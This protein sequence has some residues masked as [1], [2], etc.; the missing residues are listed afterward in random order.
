MRDLRETLKLIANASKRP[1]CAIRKDSS[2]LSVIA[3]YCAGLPIE[4]SSDLNEK[5]YWFL[6][7]LETY[8]ICECHGCQNKTA[9]RG[10]KRGYATTCCSKHAAIVSRPKAIKTNLA[11]YG[12]PTPLQNREIR[13]KINMHNLE[14]YGSCNVVESEYFKE[15]RIRTCQKNF[16][17]DFPMQNGEV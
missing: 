14:K 16:G 8:P 5:A 17:V 9:F 1:V 3:E 15:K 12:S 10:L 2:L 11:K 4:S 13:A 6:N 7:R